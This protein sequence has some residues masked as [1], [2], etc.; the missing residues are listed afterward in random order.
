MGPALGSEKRQLWKRWEA[1]LGLIRGT[2]S[3]DGA[4]LLPACQPTEQGLALPIGFQATDDDL[5]LVCGLG[6]HL[7]LPSHILVLDLKGVEC[8]LGDCPQEAHRILG[9]S[10]STPPGEEKVLCLGLEKRGTWRA[11]ET[12][13]EADS[14]LRALGTG[15]G[16]T[17]S[18][19]RKGQAEKQG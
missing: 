14:F 3:R 18:H 13:I 7:G 11:T 12:V 2:L 16:V 10:L 17:T 15:S 9:Q 19:V 8:A 4:Q 5:T 1:A 6:Y